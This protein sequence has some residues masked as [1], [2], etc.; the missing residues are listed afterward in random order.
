MN[1]S[2]R[3]QAISHLLDEQA[4]EDAA[5]VYYAYHHPDEKTSLVLYPPGASRAEGYV[6]VSR[7]GIDL[8]R[9]LVTMRLPVDDPVSSR[10][11]LDQVLPPGS[12]AIIYSPAA[13]L[14]LLQAFFDIS[15]EEHLQLYVLDPGRFEPIINVLV[16]QS[17]T[18]DGLPRFV[19]RSQAQNDQVVASAGLNWQTRHFADV[20]VHTSAGHRRQGW[21]QSVVA[22]MVQYVL[23]SG[24][25]PL[26]VVAANNIASIELARRVGFRDS[27]HRRII[28]QA[29]RKQLP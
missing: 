19:I 23:D 9:P 12:G 3:R 15:S 17:T 8:F 14:P 29:V 16:V 26:Y 4:P 13:Y 10:E 27:G 21:G 18:P 5:A 6:A 28:L 20:S 25:T 2:E 24:R 11:L 1:L 7:T 22:A